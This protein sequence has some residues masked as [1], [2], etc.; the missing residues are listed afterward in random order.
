MAGVLEIEAADMKGEFTDEWG[1]TKPLLA[2]I[3]RLRVEAGGRGGGWGCATAWAD[4][5]ARQPAG[6]GAV[7]G[8]RTEVPSGVREVIDLKVFLIFVSSSRRSVAYRSYHKLEA[9]YPNQ[10]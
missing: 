6:V 5:Q 8:F 9:M 2:G 3:D 1:L 7:W 4:L 10:M